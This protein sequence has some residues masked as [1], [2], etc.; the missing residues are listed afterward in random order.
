[1]S[2]LYVRT[3]STSVFLLRTPNSLTLFSLGLPYRSVADQRVASEAASPAAASPCVSPASFY[4]GVSPPPPPSPNFASY[5]EDDKENRDPLLP[6]ERLKAED[7]EEPGTS[8]H[9]GGGGGRGG[10]R[11][12]GLRA[13]SARS[14]VQRRKRFRSPL[15]S[16]AAPVTDRS[17]AASVPEGGV[18]GRY[19]GFDPWGATNAHPRL[20]AHGEA[21]GVS[22][23]AAGCS[24]GDGSGGDGNSGSGGGSRLKRRRT[25]GVGSLAP[26][27][28]IRGLDGGALG[29]RGNARV[30]GGGS[31]QRSKSVRGET[32][33]KR[34][35]RCSYHYC[36]CCCCCF[37]STFARVFLLFSVAR[38]VRF[39]FF[40]RVLIN[41]AA[42]EFFLFCFSCGVCFSPEFKDHWY[43]G[44]E[45]KQ[46][47][48]AREW[49]FSYVAFCVWSARGSVLLFPCWGSVELP[50]PM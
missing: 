16:L 22:A 48:D 14:D 5:S 21:E 4:A 46:G 32:R 41:H 20:D 27:G 33:A 37:F 25:L 1:M 40:S 15:G 19:P 36:C 18:G 49:N 10:G 24:S 39:L 26:R 42:L 23:A 7:G 3:A 13:M 28:L 29:L 44:M 17:S 31:F 8:K 47:Q 12:G 2:G 11:G 45:G 30:D 35:L 43:V 6:H 9:F 50:P 34:R 38:S